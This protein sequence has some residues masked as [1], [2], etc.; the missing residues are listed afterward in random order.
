MYWARFNFINQISRANK[1]SWR[2]PKE[3]DILPKSILLLLMMDIFYAFLEFNHQQSNKEIRLYFGNMD[4]KIQQMVASVMMSQD[5]QSTFWLDRDMMFG[6]ATQEEIVIQE[7]TQP[8]TQ[9]RR[10][11]GI[12]HFTIWLNTI[13]RQF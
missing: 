13:F 2:I 4:L 11:F 1:V 3:M 5:Q 12:S 7:I 6:L 8:S 10:N 9:I